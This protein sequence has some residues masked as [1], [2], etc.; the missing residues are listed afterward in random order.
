M[1]QLLIILFSDWFVRDYGLSYLSLR[2]SIGLWTAFLC[3]VLVAT[4]ASSLVCYI[5]RFTEEAF[6]AL[7]CIIFIYEALEKLFHLGEVYPINMHNHLDNLTFYTCQCSP[8]ANASAE[9]QQIWSNS[10]FGPGSIPWS[11]LS[12]QECMDLR[13][14][15]VGSACGHDGPFIPDVLFWSVI[16]FFTTFFLS[17]FLKQFKTKR[18]FPTKVR[19]TISDFAIFLTIMIMV[20]VDYL[21]GV[22]SP[23]LNVPDRFE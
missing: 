2:T 7:I 13:G 6:A 23:K 5:T 4:D 3:L 22:P 15:F 1:V 11:Q 18:Y 8:P 17:S 21:V 12:V 19:S 20:L 16:L 14:E 9:V 10:S